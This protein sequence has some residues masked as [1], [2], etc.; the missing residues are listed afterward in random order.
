MNESSR[1][2]ML[3]HECGQRLVKEPDVKLDILV[4]RRDFLRKAAFLITRAPVF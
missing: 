3:G 1:C 4:Y 2:L